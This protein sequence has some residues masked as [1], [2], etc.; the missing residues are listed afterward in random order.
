M[1][2]SIRIS[3]TPVALATWCSS[4]STKTGRVQG[5]WLGM[6]HFCIITEALMASVGSGTDRQDRLARILGVLG[7]A[8]LRFWRSRSP[9]PPHR[10]R[11]PRSRCPSG[12]RWL[13]RNPH[14]RTAAPAAHAVLPAPA[15]STTGSIASS[16]IIWSF[17]GCALGT[18]H[19]PA[20]PPACESFRTV[21]QYCSD[22]PLPYVSLPPSRP[23]Y[24]TRA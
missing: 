11:Q 8:H 7:A 14:L 24:C 18:F 3:K 12:L 2:A 5:M 19:E 23:S 20:V 1:C 22:A 9:L 13:A 15:R 6:P 16:S 17:C 10:S 21:V 4:H